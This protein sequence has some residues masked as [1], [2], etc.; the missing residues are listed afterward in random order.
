MSNFQSGSAEDN[1]DFPHSGFSACIFSFKYY[2]NSTGKNFKQKENSH[3]KNPL[4]SRRSGTPR[5]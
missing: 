5:P 3:G 1:N 2:S 4:G